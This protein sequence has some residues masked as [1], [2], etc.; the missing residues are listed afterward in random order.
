ML[1]SNI[2]VASCSV[3]L[4]WLVCGFLTGPPYHTKSKEGLV[5]SNKDIESDIMDRTKSQENESL[6]QKIRRLR[7]QMNEMHQVW[8][9]GLP[10]PPFPTID[11]A[12]TLSLPLKS[13][14]QFPIF[15]DAL[16]HD[17]EFLSSQKL[18]NASVTLPLAS[19][20][21]PATLTS[22]HTTCAFGAQPS[23]ETS[24]LAINPMVVL[25]QYASRH[26][27]NTL[28]YHCYTPYPT[29]MLIVQQNFLTRSL[30]CQ[31]S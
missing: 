8:A 23:V 26:M 3:S 14:S 16:Q 27:F 29:S 25:P 28:N 11:S 19:Q 13:Q 18:P 15:V 9:S 7:Q 22:P 5:V 12:N 1:N 31:K 6:K 17:S 21:K 24:T 20:Y 30:A 4:K 10:L 2:F